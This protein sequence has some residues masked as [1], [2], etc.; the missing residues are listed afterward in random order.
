MSVYGLGFEIPLTA[1]NQVSPVFHEISSD[2][3]QMSAEVQA[4]SDELT[5]KLTSDLVTLGVGATSVAHLAEEFGFL[6]REQARTISLIGSVTS[7]IASVVRALQILISTTSVATAVQNALNI[8]HAT[9]LALTG[10]GIA[11]IIAAAAA[12]TY[13]AAQ[14]NAAT[15]AAERYNVAAEAAAGHTRSITR[16]GE[17]EL[18]RRGI[19]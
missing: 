14:M 1:I 5:R 4:T 9:F 13:F 12:M 6:N 17:D 18:S 16:A 2:A 3:Q 10:V 19:E 8:S 11:V 7:T 15:A